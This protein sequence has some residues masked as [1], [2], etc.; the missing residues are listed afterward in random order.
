[1]IFISQIKAKCINEA[2]IGE[3][4][5]LVMQEELNQ[6]KENNVWELFSRL[7]TNLL[8]GTKWFFHNKHDGNKL[9]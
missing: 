4:W 2:L 1:M 6:F 8:I 5:S 9:F 3:H 7:M